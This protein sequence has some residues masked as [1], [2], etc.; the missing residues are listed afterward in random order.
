M[1]DIEGATLEAIHVAGPPGA[2]TL[3]FLHG[4]LGSLAAWR[5]F[6]PKMAAALGYGWM[7]YSRRGHGRSS[8]LDPP[9]DTIYLDREAIDVLPALLERLGIVRPILFGQGDG[10]AIAL[11]HAAGS[12][13]PVEAVIVES[14]LVLI[15]EKTLTGILAIGRPAHLGELHDRPDAVFDAWHSIWLSPEFRD[16]SIVHRLPA[17]TAPV[18]A[19]QGKDNPYG[20]LGQTDA[21][22]TACGGRVET[23]LLEGV[24]LGPHEEVPV[25]VIDAVRTF[26]AGR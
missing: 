23:L 5:D 7:A 11:I 16:W 1:I 4:A 21:I 25:S 18:L 6:P 22:S 14:P 26:L 24:G 17:I 9:R 2:P 8:P 15:E 19:I 13:E 20:S 3:V 10:S 12:G